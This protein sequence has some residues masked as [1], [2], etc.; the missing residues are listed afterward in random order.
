M[1]FKFRPQRGSLRAAMSE[2]VELA[3]ADALR[4]HLAP[5]TI[6]SVEPYPHPQ[7]MHDSRIGWDTYIVIARYQ[8][9][10]IHPCGFTNAPVELRR[11]E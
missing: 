8:N 7:S 3:D 4:V 10:M 5:L 1:A 11:A 9:G 2:C 6:V